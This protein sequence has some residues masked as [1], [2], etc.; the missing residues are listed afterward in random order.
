MARVAASLAVLLGASSAVR[1]DDKE[2]WTDL[3]NR[4]DLT[5]WVIDGPR[6]YKDKADGNK[7]KPL[8]TV[9]DGLVRTAGA[10]FGFLRYNREFADF[11]LHV[12]YRMVKEKG[13]N[14]GI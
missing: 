10:A 3:F 9:E 7:V 4:K 1:A 5:G 13:V 12:E 6:E 14:S 11:I 8:W 2:G